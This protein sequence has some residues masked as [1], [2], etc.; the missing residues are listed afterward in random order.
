M[1]EGFWF[2]VAFKM[3]PAPYP[4][5]L[6]LLLALWL[7]VIGC[8]FG[9][10]HAPAIAVVAACINLVGSALVES[11]PGGAHSWLWFVYYRSMD[12]LILIATFAIWWVRRKQ[13]RPLELS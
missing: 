8:L 2:F 5:Q 11:R 4:H 1:I 13:Q 3:G 7:L 9:F 10:R 6:W 12:A